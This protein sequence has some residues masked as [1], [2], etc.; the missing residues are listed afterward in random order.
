MAFISPTGQC[1][2]ITTASP[3]GERVRIS[4][5]SCGSGRA[6]PIDG[7]PSFAPISAS[8]SSFPANAPNIIGSEILPNSSLIP[9]YQS[10]FDESRSQ[11]EGDK[12]QS[13][14]SGNPP[15]GRPY[16]WKYGNS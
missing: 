1:I 10:K 12:Q 6:F 3:G 15:T 8:E 11:K 7:T 2:P 5:T 9:N 13:D 4:S 16:I 14:S